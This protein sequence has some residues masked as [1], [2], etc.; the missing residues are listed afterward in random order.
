MPQGQSTTWRRVF[1]VQSEVINNDAGGN[2]NS[3]IGFVSTGRSKVRSL[4]G[5]IHCVLIMAI[6]PL[7]VVTEEFK[8]QPLNSTVLQ[9]SD[10]RYTATVVGTWQSMTWTVGEYLVATVHVPGTGNI[11]VFSDQYAARFC[12]ED[13]ISCVEFFMY[14]VTRGQSGKVICFVMGKYGS[15]T[16]DLY[17]QVVRVSISGGTVTATQGDQVEFQCAT[18][19]WFPDPT[20]TWTRNGEAVNSSLYNTTSVNDVNYFNS[21]SVLKFQAERNTR[22]ECL[23]TVPTLTK[24]IQ[25][26]SVY[27]VVVPKPPDWT[28]LIA[29]VLSFS[30][31]ALLALLI[32]GIIFCYK[33][34]KEKQLTY[35]DEMRSPTPICPS[36]HLFPSAELCPSP[37]LHLTSHTTD[38]LFPLLLHMLLSYLPAR[39][40]HGPRQASAATTGSTKPSAGQDEKKNNVP[41]DFD[42]DMENPET[43]K[44]AVAIQSQ[45]R[46]FQ[47]KKQDVKS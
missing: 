14:N 3:V 45:F 33:R 44:A 30:C 37:H 22:V 7:K 20:I 16:A 25:S 4:S 5:L 36:N 43:E 27:L 12:V 31:A 28:V 19:L 35:Q 11:S 41:E 26:S 15:K 17:V 6:M 8:L 40:H 18:F 42:I 29:V 34:R 47:K 24:P 9:G 21:T 23:A 2:E 13:D 39:L 10:V 46:K 38:L 32:I 1:P